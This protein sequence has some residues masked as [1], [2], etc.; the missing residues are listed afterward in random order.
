[1]KR[2]RKELKHKKNIKK[3]IHHIH[4][5]E[6]RIIKN[7]ME[8]NNL[9]K[10]LKDK[11]NDRTFDP[12][13]LTISYMAKILRTLNN[14][15]KIA[16]HSSS[17]EK[18][19]HEDIRLCIKDYISTKELLKGML[20]TKKGENIKKADIQ[21][22]NSLISNFKNIESDFTNNIINQR[23]QTR[24]IRHNHQKHRDK[25]WRSDD[26]VLHKIR[27][28]SKSLF[29]ET[30]HERKDISDIKVVTRKLK[31]ELKLKNEEKINVNAIEKKIEKFV[32]D[33]ET[34]LTISKRIFDTSTII[35]SYTVPLFFDVTDEIEDLK[36]FL[37][38]LEK[39][40]YYHYKDL[41]KKYKDLED[42]IKDLSELEDKVEKVLKKE[43][44]HDNNEV[45]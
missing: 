28:M 30:K 5:L 24:D 45:K 10:I 22:F 33:I 18:K 44:I 1:M 37:E 11:I 12:K 29:S 16:L 7:L 36:G 39:S 20:D 26:E 35:F 13:N 32:K 40:N 38:I 15:Y 4:E 2:A 31:R 23:N 9:K 3:S 14:I 21:G 6:S 19:L 27:R 41:K 43:I 42:D 34:E 25:T 8:L 17:I